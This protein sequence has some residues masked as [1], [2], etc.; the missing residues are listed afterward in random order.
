MG[1]L[2]QKTKQEEICIHTKV[3]WHKKICHMMQIVME[4]HV[5]ECHVMECHIKVCH[6]ME[7]QAMKWG[8]NVWK[9]SYNVRK[10]MWIISLAAT[11][12]HRMRYGTTQHREM[13]LQSNFT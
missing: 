10:Y 5:M 8:Y 9:C 1:S 2:K 4:C 11:W 13:S 12:K 3:Q 7:C 6:V